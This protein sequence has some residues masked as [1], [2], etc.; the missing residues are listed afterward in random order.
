MI[1]LVLCVLHSPFHSNDDV[2]I[3]HSFDDNKFAIGR[4][5]RLHIS[6]EWWKMTAPMYIL[7]RK[8]L[9]VQSI[10]ITTCHLYV[11]GVCLVVTRE[12]GLDILDLFLWWCC[13]CH[14]VAVKNYNTF[15][16]D[17]I[18]LIDENPAA[19][20]TAVSFVLGHKIWSSSHW[21]MAY[22]VFHIS[23]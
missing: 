8:C 22:I 9:K 20:S 13:D 19:V 23:Q 16:H 12:I 6:L 4:E 10:Y 21:T 7:R 2:I 11:D 17:M 15:C 1:P 18:V 14:M 3:S 5:R